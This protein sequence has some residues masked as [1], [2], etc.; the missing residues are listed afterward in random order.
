LFHAKAQRRE[1]FWQTDCSELVEACPERLQDSR[2]G[3]LLF[4]GATKKERGLDK[5]STK[6][7]GVFFAPSRFC[8]RLSFGFAASETRLDVYLNHAQHPRHDSL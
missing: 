6:G 4:L 1:D 3:L 2:R 7:L 8:V 5:L